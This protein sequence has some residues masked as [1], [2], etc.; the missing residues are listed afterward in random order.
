[1]ETE[2][3]VDDEVVMA[4]LTGPLPQRSNP[5][6]EDLVL[7]ADDMDFAGWCLSPKLPA[8]STVSVS[9]ALPAP[10]DRRAAAPTPT[11]DEPGLGI[12][13]SGSHRWW[14]AGLAGA[15]STM[16]I[17]LLLLSLSS[18]GQFDNEGFSIIRPPVKTAPNPA[19]GD[20]KNSIDPELTRV[21]PAR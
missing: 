2:G 9:A 11:F 10:T 6:P 21:A 7:S 1:M 8:R 4:L 16:L 19:D 18:R 15:L 14:I 20:A 17:S 13:H 12:P 5:P 3:F